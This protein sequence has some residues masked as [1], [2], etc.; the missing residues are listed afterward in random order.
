MNA[1]LSGADDAKWPAI[2]KPAVSGKPSLAV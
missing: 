2:E 1:I